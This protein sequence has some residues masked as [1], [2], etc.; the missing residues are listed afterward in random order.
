MASLEIPGLEKPG[1][2]S[3]SVGAVTLIPSPLNSL[4]GAIRAADEG[5]YAAKKGGRKRGVVRDLETEGI[6]EVPP[7]A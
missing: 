7:L 6:S 5:L 4:E 3:A 2:L 1:G